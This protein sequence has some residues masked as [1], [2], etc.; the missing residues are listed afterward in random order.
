MKA[1]LDFFSLDSMISLFYSTLLSLSLSL[2]SIPSHSASAPPQLLRLI[3]ILLP[4]TRDPFFIL[5][6]PNPRS[7]FPPS[8]SRHP[9]SSSQPLSFS[10]LVFKSG[11]E[12]W[13]FLGWFRCG[14]M[15]GCDGVLVDGIWGFGESIFG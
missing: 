10:T 4:P 14:W 9:L 8:P 15:G 5:L 7:L 12:V 13:P 11:R 1:I 3:P 2:S 6:S